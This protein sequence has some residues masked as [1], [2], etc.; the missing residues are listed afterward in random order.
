MTYRVDLDVFRG[1]MDLLLYLVRKQEVDILEIPVAVIA[2]QYLDYLD[3]LQALNVND[4]GDFLVLAS[5]L[6][7]IKSRLALPRVVEEE[8][9]DDPRE[10]LVRQLLDYKRYRDAASLLDDCGRQ[11]SQRYTRLSNDLPPRGRNLAE[12]PIREVELWDLVSAFSRIVRDNEASQAANIVYDDTPIEVYMNRIRERL[13]EAGRVSFTELFQA[14]MH[15]STLIGMFLAVLEL[16]RHHGVRTMQDELFSE[17]Q[18][19]PG[20]PPD[21]D[22]GESLP[23]ATSANEPHPA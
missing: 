13:Q 12:E 17:I 22:D 9:E 8:V 2:R 21:P 10:D 1:P 5:T 15:K 7:E 20:P 23:E 19:T 16:T 4:V 6:A 11:W 3:V 18:L 14:G